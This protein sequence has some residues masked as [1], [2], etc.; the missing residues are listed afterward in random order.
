[1]LDEQGILAGIVSTLGWPSKKQKN[2]MIERTKKDFDILV[3][4][5]CNCKINVRGI[6]EFNHDILMKE[7]N[8]TYF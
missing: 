7:K 2:E 8:D 5:R 6:N 4:F 1:M 3:K